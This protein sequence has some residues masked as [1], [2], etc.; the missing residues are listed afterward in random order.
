[1]NRLP[2]YI[3]DPNESNP[4]S[5][6]KLVFS[7]AEYDEFMRVTKEAGAY[8]DFSNN[9]S[10]KC[11]ICGSFIVLDYLKPTLKPEALRRTL[12]AKSAGQMAFMAETRG[13]A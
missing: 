7:R 8:A 5:E 12:P 3:N 10:L 2:I 6:D 13:I 11:E 1:M 4:S 9:I